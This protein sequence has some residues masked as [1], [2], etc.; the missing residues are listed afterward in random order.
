MW[1]APSINAEVL[2]VITL[3]AMHTAVHLR[4]LCRTE[5][6][7]TASRQSCSTALSSP[8]LL[9]ALSPHSCRRICSFLAEL[10]KHIKM[11]LAVTMTTGHNYLH[12]FPPRI[13]QF[14]QN[15]YKESI[16]EKKLDNRDLWQ[17]GESFQI[18]PDFS[19]TSDLLFSRII[20]PYYPMLALCKEK[21][22]MHI[23]D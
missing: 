8:G 9:A 17:C 2:R 23:H 4:V 19:C 20:M 16:F 21:M 5:Q 1:S 3:Q 11:S 12:L 10:S 22:N 18:F 6:A 7:R 13:L 15:C 14:E